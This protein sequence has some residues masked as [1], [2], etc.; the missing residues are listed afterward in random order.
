MFRA[1]RLTLIIVSLKQ[2]AIV[3]T[4]CPFLS[5]RTA[6]NEG[7]MVLGGGHISLD[8]MYC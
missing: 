7:H 2:S 4:H 3:F 5:A 6:S 8:A 1:V